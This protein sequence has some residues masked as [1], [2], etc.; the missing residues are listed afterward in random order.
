M[1]SDKISACSKQIN[2]LTFELTNAKR[3]FSGLIEHNSKSNQQ[4][5]PLNDQSLYLT[6]KNSSA[7]RLPRTSQP[8]TEA[9]AQNF[10]LANWQDKENKENVSPAKRPPDFFDHQRSVSKTGVG[11]HINILNDLKLNKLIPTFLEL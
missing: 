11:Q 3:E 1:L 6:T 7:K 9:K 10:I 2:S 4:S 8:T 5:L